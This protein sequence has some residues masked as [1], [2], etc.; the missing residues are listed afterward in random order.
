MALFATGCGNDAS[1]EEKQQS[2]VV[3]SQNPEK[4]NKKIS[5]KTR[6]KKINVEGLSMKVSKK[7]EDK[8]V[9]EMALYKINDFDNFSVVTEIAANKTIEEYVD[10]AINELSLTINMTDVVTEDVEFNGYKGKAITYDYDLEGKSI[11]VY[12]ISFLQDEKAYVLTL[13]SE[14]DT[15]EG[16]ISLLKECLENMKIK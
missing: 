11:K 14:P 2:S 13:C 8:S 7:W 6:L 16:N 4:T 9:E 3:E 10:N 5:K 12:Q 15:I 1:K